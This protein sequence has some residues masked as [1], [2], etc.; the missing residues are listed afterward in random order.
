MF[1][2]QLLKTLG[3]QRGAG[4]TWEAGLDVESDFLIER[5]GLSED[6]FRLRDASGLSA[7]N[8]ITPRALARVLAYARPLAAVQAALPVAAA[9]QGSLRTRMTDLPG[10]VRAKTGG[11]R[12]VDALAGYVTTDEGRELVF[13]VIAN[14]SAFPG[15]LVRGAI[16]DVVRAAAAVD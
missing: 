5:V 13:V 1:A 11:I 6:E 15:S 14:G 16:D 7:G 4:G 3:R 9:Q 8:L 2:E 12:N 10:R